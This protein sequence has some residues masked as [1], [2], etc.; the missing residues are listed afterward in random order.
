MKAFA[1]EEEKAKYVNA[2]LDCVTALLDQLAAETGDVYLV[3]KF[4]AISS[5]LN[6]GW[7]VHKAIHD[8]EDA[9]VQRMD[10]AGYVRDDKKGCWVHKEPPAP[11]RQEEYHGDAAD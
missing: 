4:S 10:R 2:Q 1:S 11:A 5:I 3:L 6:L 9:L 8:T 7:N